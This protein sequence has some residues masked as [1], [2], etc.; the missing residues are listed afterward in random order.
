MNAFVVARSNFKRIMLDVEM[1]I[2]IYEH[3]DCIKIRKGCF[4]PKTRI[5]INESEILLRSPIIFTVTAFE[6][7]IESI[8]WQL[9]PHGLRE[10]IYKKLGYFNS[11]KG[12]NINDIFKYCDIEN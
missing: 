1:L 2:A 6:I 8:I 4:D 9:C 12:K 7:Y 10:K 3:R 11:P 5:N